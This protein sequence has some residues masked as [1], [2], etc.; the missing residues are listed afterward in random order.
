LKTSAQ[1]VPQLIPAGEDVTVPAPVP[2][3]MT[4]SVCCVRANVAVTVVAAVVL[5]GAGGA[6]V[7]AF[8]GIIALAF[9]VFATRLAGGMT[10]DLYG[11]TVEITEA[12][13][14][15]FIAAMANRGWLDAWALA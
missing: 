9:G 8:A 6:Y 10:G 12:V 11:A 15:L 14:L 2:A 5:F 13:M 4:V 7:V 1:S 3:R